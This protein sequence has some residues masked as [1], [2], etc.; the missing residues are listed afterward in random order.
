[1]LSFAG[2]LLLV[3]TLQCH[4]AYAD[5]TFDDTTAGKML[6]E[7][8]QAEN[9]RRQL[10]LQE[11][12]LAEL[13]VTIVSIRETLAVQKEQIESA[14]KVIEEQ[15]KIL[16]LKDQDCKAQV[17]AATPSFMDRM[18]SHIAAGGVGAIIAVI[19]V[20]II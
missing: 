2:A 16:D 20:L 3:A 18:M 6:V 8:E 12:M 4:E 1:M 15:K 11:Q 14:S 7:L 13:G 9:I 5:V 10:A 17:K 19:V